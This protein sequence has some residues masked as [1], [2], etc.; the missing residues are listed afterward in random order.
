MRRWVL[1]MM[2]GL[3]GCNLIGPPPPTLVN[4]ADWRTTTGQPLTSAEFEAL[5]KSCEPRTG[6]IPID[7]RARVENPIEA[8]PAFHPGGVG[9]MSATPTGISTI[10]SPVAVP[11]T[12]VERG[13]RV[14]LEECLES[15]GLVRAP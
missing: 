6:E 10:D 5:R 13:V 1:T 11:A 12:R 8:N 2:L 3:A 14:P 9:L 7:P 4:I 15:K